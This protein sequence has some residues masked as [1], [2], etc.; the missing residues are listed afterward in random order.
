MFPSNG[1]DR[2][3][4][5]LCALAELRDRLRAGDVW[6]TGSRQDRDFETYLPPAATFSVLQEEPLPLDVG[7]LAARLGNEGPMATSEY[8][9]AAEP[10]PPPRGP[11]PGACGAHEKMIISA[12]FG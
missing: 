11:R 10:R 5:E 6:V 8:L 12:G 4:Y 3:F 2:R 9:G 1:V 7:T